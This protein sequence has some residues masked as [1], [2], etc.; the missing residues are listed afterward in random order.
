MEALCEIFPQATLFALVHV[1]GALS[2]ALERMPIRTSFI[3]DLPFAERRFRYYLPLFPTAIQQFDLADF[4]LVISSH[5][6]VAKGV[7]TLPHTL[8]ICYCYTPMRYLWNLYD[9]YF[10]K[11]RA[12]ALTRIGMSAVRGYLRRWDVQTASHPHKFVAISENVRRRIAGI[13]KR[14]SD[15]IYPPVD[16]AMFPLSDRDD[17]YY[18]M[19]SALVPYKR[20]DLAIET[21]NRISAKLV[22][23]GD[24]PDAARLK[25]IARGRVEFLG[26]QTDDQ[27][28]GIYAGC[29][30]VIFPGEEDF[31][32]VPVEAMAC[33]K[34]VIAFARG[35]ALET[36][37]ETPSQRTGVLFGEQT[38]E[39]LSGAIDRFTSLQFSPGVLRAFALTFDR[40][41][42][43]Q[44]MKACVEK[45]WEEF[46]R[47][48]VE[49]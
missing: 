8:H 25:S 35:G 47:K 33:G 48:A 4:D 3:E 44:R 26:W 40:E 11:G 10:E 42:Y 31:G 2:P 30:A 49:H 9:D 22:I 23:V 34:P 13:Y 39:S 17:G 1:K 14:T 29:K 21:F 16:T 41:V 15:V 28:R 24:G 18:L 20:I 19:V 27:L 32:I 43:K 12:G 38:P 45:A 36:V 7:R 46:T 37:L 5:H 6:C